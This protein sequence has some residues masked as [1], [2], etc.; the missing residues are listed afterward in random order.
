MSGPEARQLATV[1][2]VGEETEMRVP[3]AR[4]TDH[5]GAVRQPTMREDQ[6]YLPAARRQ[7]E[8]DLRVL[9]QASPQV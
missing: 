9:T 7:L 8:S 6:E 2:D 5:R 4:D 1:E 3:A